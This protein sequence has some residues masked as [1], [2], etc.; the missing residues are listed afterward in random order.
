[1]QDITE[2]KKTEEKLK[3]SVE[4]YENVTK[5]TSDAI[6]DWDVV[7]NVVYRA[8]GFKTS[9]GFD[10]DVL[11]APDTIWEN[12]IHPDDGAI[13]TQSIYD[14][15]NSNENYWKK[16]YRIIKPDGHEAFVQDSAY[17]VRDENNKVVRIIGA[18]K[19]ITERKETELAIRKS[20]ER[21]ELIGK[22]ANDAIWE[23]D[24]TANK[25]WANVIHQ[26]LFG[27]TIEDAVPETD[28]WIS[29]LHP[30]ERATILQSFD[31]TVHAKRDIFYAEYQ[32]RTENK[33]WISVSDRTYVEYNT[34]GDVV[35]KI[36][37][38]S[39]ITQRKQEEL[40]LKL[41]SSVATNT[42]D[43]VLITEAEPFDDPGP[44][45]IYVNDAFTKMTGYA[46]EEI[47]GKTPRILQGP[48]SD[49]NE[50]TRL[51]KALENWESFEMTIVNYKK[52]G[53]EFWVNLTV[54][55]VADEKGWF[56]HWIAIQRDVTIR[57]N[58]ELQNELIA[59]IST[60][61]NESEKL[62]ET[63]D[64]ALSLITAFW[65]FL[66]CRSLDNG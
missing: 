11:N 38:M 41:M 52:N 22:A 49:K 43:A 13:A 39:D 40:Q 27:L 14:T 4:R 28:E 65:R 35:R 50:L 66:F 34:N 37:S 1:M 36:G 32:L 45:I 57:K 58:E 60:V 21:F 46:A 3:E 7:T 56:T 23:W 51:R 2:R 6:W 8:E 31:E 24:F 10:L 33:G 20:N 64:R 5:A 15:I 16:E 12:Y 55:P 9:F 48:K 29:R 53:E 54:S 44:K 47:I 30:N 61:F 63:L 25:G 19:D 42:D 17:L 18:L 26:Q 62:H 59:D